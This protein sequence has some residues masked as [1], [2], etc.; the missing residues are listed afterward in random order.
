MM[1]NYQILRGSTHSKLTKY[2]NNCPKTESDILW[3]T[4]SMLSISDPNNYQTQQNSNPIKSKSAYISIQDSNRTKSDQNSTES[5]QARAKQP[6]QRT[7]P[8]YSLQA[9]AKNPKVQALSGKSQIKRTPK[10][11]RCWQWYLSSLPNKQNQS[12]LNAE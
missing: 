8:S 11:K 7:Q 6:N 5:N 2:D 3:S 1:N 12:T 10:C 4:E 9:A